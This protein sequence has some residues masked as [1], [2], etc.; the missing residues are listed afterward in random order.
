MPKIGQNYGIVPAN[1]IVNLLRLQFQAHSWHFLATFSQPNIYAFVS[2]IFSMLALLTRIYG[3]VLADII[4]IILRLQFW[5]LPRSDHGLNQV[6]AVCMLFF[7][8]VTICYHI[9]HQVR[10]YDPSQLSKLLG[11]LGRNWDG[12]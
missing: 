6:E 2:H 11:Q 9:C 10:R 3:T 4:V 8:G 5:A 1:I 12:F 7:L